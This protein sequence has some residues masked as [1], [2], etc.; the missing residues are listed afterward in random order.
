MMN[1]ELKAKPLE[2]QAFFIQYL[3]FPLWRVLMGGL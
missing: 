1:Y 3:S 2:A